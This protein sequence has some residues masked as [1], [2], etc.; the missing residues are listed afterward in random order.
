M[1]NN[2]KL[3]YHN[4]ELANIIKY[5]NPFDGCWIELD[6]PITKKEVL[7][8]VKNKQEEL[9]QTPIW[10]EIAFNHVK[11]TKEAIRLNHIKKIA[12]FV[13]NDI[14]DPISLEVGVPELNVYID[15]IVDDGNHRLAAAIIKNQ[16]IIK[17]TLSGST[18]HA[19][20]LGLWNPNE[21]ELK[22]IEEYEK[23]YKLKL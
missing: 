22:E 17:A 21:F 11:L 10:T 1:E 20:E 13:V 9:T 6:Y 18:S 12:Y 7:E 8:C 23:K 19:K 16:K 15:Y 14:Q 4:L 3:A 2:Q 5:A